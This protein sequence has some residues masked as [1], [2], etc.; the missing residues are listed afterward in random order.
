ML[1]HIKL[2]ECVLYLVHFLSN[3]IEGFQYISERIVLKEADLCIT[4][5]LSVNGRLFATPREHLDALVSI[6][7]A[8]Y[9]NSLK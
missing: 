7:F 5:G 9:I 8:V 6:A 2:C 4:T 1:I 3:I